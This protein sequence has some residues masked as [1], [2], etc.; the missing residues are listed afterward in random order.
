[1]FSVSRLAPRA[2][3]GLTLRAVAAVSRLL[4][5]LVSTVGSSL[6][7]ASLGALPTVVRCRS[8]GRLP[9]PGLAAGPA[10]PSERATLNTNRASS[11]A[12]GVFLSRQSVV[13]GVA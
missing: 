11:L 2:S 8:L 12:L 9:A 10:F 13:H 4:L 6:R 7:G 5:L 3:S 1:M